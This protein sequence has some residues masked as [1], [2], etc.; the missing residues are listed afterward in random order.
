MLEGVFPRSAAKEPELLA[1]HRTEAGRLDEAIPL[2]RSAGESALARV[3]LQE[4]VAYLEKG[5]ALARSP[6]R[7]LPN[8]TSLELSLREPLH[9]A[10]LTVAGMGGARG[11]RER[12][13]VAASCAD[14]SHDRQSL[15][16]GLWGM[17]VNTITQG[18]IAE[19]PHVGA[20]PAGRRHESRATSTCRSSGTARAVVAFLSRASCRKRWTQRE[21]DPGALRPTARRA[22]DGADGERCEDRGRRL[23]V[24]GAVD[25]RLSRPARAAISDQKDADARQLGHPFDI[26]W[27]LTWGGYVFD[28]RREPERL[29]AQRTRG[30]SARARAEHSRCSREL[31]VPMAEGLALLRK[32]ELAAA[33][34]SLR[35]GIDAWKS[36]GGH[37]NL[38]VHEVGAGRSAGAPGRPRWRSCA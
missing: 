8:A 15:L 36:R 33:V 31:L 32:G 5:L 25:A 26:G 17:W 28:Y 7:R 35:L 22:M 2:W 19:T 10:R 11:W 24:A 34:T 14:N 30:R 3:A 16:V 37:L 12:R 18:R 27:A 23:R 38:P 4:A 21:R 1:H 29:M 9:S 13:G 20:T 6:A